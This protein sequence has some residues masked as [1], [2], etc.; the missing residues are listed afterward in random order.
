MSDFHAFVEELFAGMGPV[1]FK[2]MFGVVGLFA[3]D[4]IFGL[5]DED[6]IYLKA[7]EGLRADL[8]AEG[9]VSWVYRFQAEPKAIGAYWRLPE[10][11]LDNPDEATAWARRALAVAQ[12]KAAAKQPK[13][14]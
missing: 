4:V 2:R 3:D 11:A 14:R 5:I 9:S 12:A 13:R 1:R 6:T 10:A 8:E 7:G